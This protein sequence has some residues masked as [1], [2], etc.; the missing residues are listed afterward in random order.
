[1]RLSGKT[2]FDFTLSIDFFDD[3]GEGFVDEEVLEEGFAYL[4]LRIG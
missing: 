1:M 2:A 4:G 3:A